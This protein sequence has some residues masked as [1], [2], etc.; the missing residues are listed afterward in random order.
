MWTV[1]AEEK[2]QRCSR[3]EVT[4][5]RDFQILEDKEAELE[6]SKPEL[7]ISPKARGQGG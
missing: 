3:L 7:R 5:A 1:Q 6:P 2:P 4:L